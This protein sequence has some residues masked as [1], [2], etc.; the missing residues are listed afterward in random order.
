MPAP[1]RVSVIICAHD[2]ARFTLLV[3]AVRS[4]TAQEPPPAQLIVVVD[5][6]L[7]LLDRA[8][9]ALPEA[10]VIP[11]EQ[12]RGLS[13]ARNTGVRASSS[14]VI[15]FLDD[16]AAARPGWLDALINAYEDPHLLGTG[17]TIL[18][19]WRA[20]RPAWF[21]D[22]FLWVV[23]CTYRGYPTTR[24]R[25]RNPIGANMS[26]RRSVFRSV[27]GFRQGVG[28]GRG[29]PLGCEETELSV[30]AARGIPD[31]YFLHEPDAVV[32]HTVTPQRGRPAYFLVRCFSEGISKAFVVKL[33]GQ[34]SGMSTER[35]YASRTLPAGV[36]R[37]LLAV[38]RGS[39]A[40]ALRAGAILIGLP[41]FGLG[42]L[43][44]LILFRADLGASVAEVP[45]WRAE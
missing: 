10:M 6:N 24:A 35:R 38:F 31:G 11:N 14:D 7:Q 28:R 36:L 26:F 21:P 23:G 3:R 8:R 29:L 43:R 17:G 22:E 39:P 15:A 45:L 34:G 33:V 40:G 25:V 20:G 41:A 18:P 5:H 42:F 1:R 9:A 2:E 19:D 16:D 27:G 30:R 37:N 13:G 12:A 4:V 44:G 32:D